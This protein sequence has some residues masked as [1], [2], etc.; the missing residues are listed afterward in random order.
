MLPHA[1]DGIKI[2]D[3]HVHRYS[4]EPVVGVLLPNV[5]NVENSV[6]AMVLSF[7]EVVSCYRR[8]RE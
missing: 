1:V 7:V 3:R 4:E 8:F 5:G 2:V 6:G